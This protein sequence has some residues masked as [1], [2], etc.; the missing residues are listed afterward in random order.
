MKAELYLGDRNEA[1]LRVTLAYYISTESRE[2]STGDIGDIVHTAPELLVG[3][4]DDHTTYSD[5]WALGMTA[6]EVSF[7]QGFL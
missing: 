4:V 2:A 6:Y 3:E 7:H 1:V 5:I